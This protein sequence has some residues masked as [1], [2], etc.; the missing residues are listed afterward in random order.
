MLMTVPSGMDDGRVGAHRIRI[1][2]GTAINKQ[3]TGKQLPLGGCTLE[4]R[5][6][7]VGIA[8]MSMHQTGIAIKQSANRFNVTGKDVRENSLTGHDW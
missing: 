5:P 7:I 8:F 6:I 1:D 3:L 2:L 4:G